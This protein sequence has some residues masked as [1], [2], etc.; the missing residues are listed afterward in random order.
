MDFS[1]YRFSRTHE[2]A[3]TDSSGQVVVGITKHAVELLNDL[4]YIELPKVGATVKAGEG[5]GEI[6]SVKAVSDLY[7]PVDGT[8]AAVNEKLSSDPM[9]I[10][11][12]PYGKGWIIKIKPS[13]ALADNL[14]SHADYE[15]L[16]E[17]EG[18]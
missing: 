5:F 11:D 10:A 6:E 12:D 17:E 4:V 14:L 15:K 18:H 9:Q 8:V 2:W 7:S 1:N 3:T 13:G 16:L